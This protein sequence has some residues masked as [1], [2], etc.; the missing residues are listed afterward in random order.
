MRASV[1]CSEPQG[2]RSA[3]TKGTGMRQVAPGAV[4][5]PHPRVTCLCSA[6]QAVTSAVL[7]WRSCG[8]PWRRASRSSCRWWLRYSAMKPMKSLAGLQGEVG[9]TVAREGWPCP[10]HHPCHAGAG[11]G[12]LPAVDLLLQPLVQLL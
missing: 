11:W 2:G 9:S 12:A 4:A 5:P 7:R 6:R 8:W 10:P 3:T 1:G